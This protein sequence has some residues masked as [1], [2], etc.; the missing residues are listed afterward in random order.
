[1][2]NALTRHVRPSPPSP[3]LIVPVVVPIVVA[4]RVPH[5]ALILSL[6]S[7]AALSHLL[8]GIAFVVIAIINKTWLLILALNSAASSVLQRLPV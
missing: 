1:M 7:L 6:L 5:L 2:E 4:N 8:D 3:R